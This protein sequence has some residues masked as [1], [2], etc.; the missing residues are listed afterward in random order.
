MSRFPSP[1]AP[2]GVAPILDSMSKV[3]ARGGSIHGGPPRSKDRH[4]LTP[5]APLAGVLVC[6]LLTGC[7][8]YNSSA[9]K[10][11]YVGDTLL[12]LGGGAAITVEET[13]KPP[14]C[15]GPGCPTYTSSLSGG[16]IAGV[17]LASAGVFGLIV[18]ATRPTVKSSR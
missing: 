5:R 13:T 1:C 12:I 4:H 7:F 6:V 14:P 9:K 8:G 2:W 11:S 16:L 10:W 18:N 17:I 15:M 3:V